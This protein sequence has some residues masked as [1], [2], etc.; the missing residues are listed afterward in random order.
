MCP[1]ASTRIAGHVATATET[2]ENTDRSPLL[3]KII[4]PVL[5]LAGA[6][7]KSAAFKGA[8]TPVHP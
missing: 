1:P 5:P 8:E 6:M 7:D 4:M 3:P 2:I